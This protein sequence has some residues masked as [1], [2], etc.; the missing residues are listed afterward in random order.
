MASI[1]WVPTP[2]QP[3]A[4]ITLS[5]NY[6]AVR[7][8]FD[9]YNH[10]QVQAFL[11][12]VIQ[13]FGPT[14]IE[15]K[16]MPSNQRW[17]YITSRTPA[18]GTAWALDFCFRDPCDATLFGLKYSLWCTL[19]GRWIN[20][21]HTINISSITLDFLVAWQITKDRWC[22]VGHNNGLPMLTVGV[23]KFARIERFTTGIHNML[24]PGNGL[25]LH[26]LAKI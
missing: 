23:L 25:L 4:A 21:T 5:A 24:L 1:S 20:A 13:D 16:S 8:V 26:P 3:E 14:R 2:N 6:T 17:C 19:Y 10:D 7:V 12:S 11:R 9:P 18:Q 15:S 22:F